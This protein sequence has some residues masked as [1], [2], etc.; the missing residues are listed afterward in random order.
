MNQHYTFHVSYYDCLTGEDNTKDSVRDSNQQL[1][2]TVYVADGEEIPF[3]E[4]SFLMKT[5]Y[6]GAAIGLGANHDAGGSTEIDF[7]NKKDAVKGG[8]TLDY[9]TGIPYWPGSSVKGTIRSAFETKVKGNYLVKE[10]LEDHFEEEMTLELYNELIEEIFGS[11]LGAKSRKGNV[12]AKQRGEDIFLDALVVKPNRQGRI[13]GADYITSH[14]LT[15]KD[16]I[17]LDEPNP[18]QFFKILPEVTFLFRFRLKDSNV[19]PGLTKELKMELYQAI[20]ETT[21]I[22]AKTNTGYGMVRSVENSAKEWKELVP[23]VK[24]NGR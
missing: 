6:P 3:A 24:G 1:L 19:Y 20:L 7:A 18:V 8:L 23:S 10:M 9:T 16:R 21:G 13:L 14:K 5:V 4:E 11:G 17:G 12:G 22:G 2:E 15:K